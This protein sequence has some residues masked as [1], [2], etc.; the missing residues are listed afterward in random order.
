MLFHLF[1]YSFKLN[2][3]RVSALIKD[4]RR[5]PLELTGDWIEFVLRHNGA[6]HLRVQSF[7][8]PWYQEHSVDVVLFI[9]FISASACILLTRCCRCLCKVCRKGDRLKAKKE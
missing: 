9:L 4:Q 7:N 6:P 3:A 1:L 5:T 8:M 2:A